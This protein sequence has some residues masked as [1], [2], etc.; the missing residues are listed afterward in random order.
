[1]LSN[2]DIADMMGNDNRFGGVL[3]K[4]YLNNHVNPTDKKVY[5]LNLDLD[6]SDGSHWVLV[7]TLNPK[8]NIYF[9]SFSLPPPQ[10]IV[11]FLEKS[12]KMKVMNNLQLQNIKSNYCGYFCVYIAKRLLKGDKYDD[13]LTNPHWNY[14]DTKK[15]DAFV[16]QVVMKMVKSKNKK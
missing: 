9:D 8:V 1:M 7:S 6:S 15:N 10:D 16:K 11:E 3:A 5:I 12:R 2:F 4:Q 13:I 14:I